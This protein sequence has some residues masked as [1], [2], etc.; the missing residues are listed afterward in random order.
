MVQDV[1]KMMDGGKRIA[2]VTATRAE[3]GQLCP[4]VQE[5][6]RHEGDG[7]RVDLVVTG[8][9]L[10]AGHGG[11][12]DE[13]KG[14]G[15]RI[16]HLVKIG[17]GSLG[18]ADIS[19]N[20]CDAL[21]GFTELFLREGYS[22]V[23]VLGDRYEMLAVCIAALNTHTPITHLSGGD[24]TEGAVDDCI[25][26]CITKMAYLHFPTN[27]G[28]RG[29]VVQLGEEP[30]RVF[31]YG[32]LSIDNA[33]RRA[34]LPKGE[35][36]RAVGLGDCRYAV[37]TYHPV[38]MGPGDDRQVLDS[39]L[40]VMGELGGIEFI[41]TGPNADQ[42]GAAI[43]KQLEGRVPGMGNA[44]LYA[45]LGARRYLSL[46]KSAEF[47]IGN[48]SSGLVEAPAFGVP[49]VNIGDRQ[50]GRLRTGSVIDCRGDKDSIRQGVSLARSAGFRARCA[51]ASR[52]FGDGH[53]AEKIAAKILEFVME[54]KFGV[55]HFYPGDV[56]REKR[57]L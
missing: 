35:A 54:D 48:S 55:K 20:Q 36:L 23:V 30:W 47:V 25:R 49:T 43:K 32:S 41:I 31:N 21:L 22:T 19:K 44:H 10:S 24:I 3:Y 16:D 29:R 6:R 13:I 17:T 50:K 39:L 26:H 7:L 57:K 56:G 40:D 27:E 18:G 34:D 9:H 52:E 8:T 11:T 4:L 38:T 37:C 1:K 53:A 5:L 15:N 46:I 33:I 12:I 2:V 14:D 45:S 42:G 28:S 51:H